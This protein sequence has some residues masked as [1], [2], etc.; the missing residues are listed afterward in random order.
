M[1]SIRDENDDLSTVAAVPVQV[2]SIRES[3]VASDPAEETV[4]TPLSFSKQGLTHTPDTCVFATLVTEDEEDG[5]DSDGV[6]GPFFDQ[7]EDELTT[8]DDEEELVLTPDQ[9]LEG[10]V[11]LDTPGDPTPNEVDSWSEAD[12]MAGK[13]K[14]KDMQQ[15]LKDRKVRYSGLR[16]QQLREKVIECIQNKT[17]VATAM[18][19][20][21][22]DNLAEG[23]FFTPGSYWK[24]INTI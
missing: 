8:E 23:G 2:D 9:V 4:G 16:A 20:E 7:V 10:T 13:Y 18:V 11:Q 5:Y 12:V 19:Q 3:P 15:F 6:I 1:S 24:A 22:R 14:N 17:P 21:V